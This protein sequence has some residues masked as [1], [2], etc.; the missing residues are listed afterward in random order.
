MKNYFL[1]SSKM[2]RASMS[3]VKGGSGITDP[4]LDPELE[5]SGSL[6]AGITDPNL[7]GPGGDN[8]KQK[9]SVVGL[10]SSAAVGITDPELAG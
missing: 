7:E 6:A 4:N 1:E 8:I 3:Q 9:T 10:G 5:S 2:N